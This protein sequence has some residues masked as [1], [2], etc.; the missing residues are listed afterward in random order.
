MVISCQGLAF[1]TTLSQ[2]RINRATQIFGIAVIRRVLC[3]SLYLLGITRA[4]IGKL[5]EV[6]PDTV[7]TII[8]NI[9]RN[10]IPA[11]EDRRYRHSAFLP[12]AQKTLP[13]K[14][15]VTLEGEWINID[16]GEKEQKLKIP[17]SNKLQFR[18]LLLTMFNSGLL[19]TKQTSEYLELSD[20]QTRTLAKDLQEKDIGS[21]LDKRQGQ[22]KDYVFTPEIKAEVIQQYSA[23]AAV[24]KKTSSMALAEDLKARCGLNLSPRTIRLYIE[25]LGLSKIKQTLPELIDTIKK[26]QKSNR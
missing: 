10:G 4:T 19:S 2:Q 15:N 14:V 12:Q 1:D 6:P 20:V 9:H 8:K 21:I 5:I 18:T 13:F 11:F 7:K 26:T 24:N 23:N 3:F 25:K 17:R 16:W 22:K